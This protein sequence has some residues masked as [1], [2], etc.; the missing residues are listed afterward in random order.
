VWH[1][2]ANLLGE[3]HRGLWITAIGAVFERLGMA[4][5]R[6]IFHDSAFPKFS[7][8][9]SDDARSAEEESAFCRQLN[10]AIRENRFL[11]QKAGF[12]MTKG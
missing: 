9:H 5:K 11:A 8:C 1:E 2:G 12:G 7:L 4:R 3:M 6:S 10:E